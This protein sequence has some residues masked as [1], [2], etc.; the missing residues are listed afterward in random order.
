MKRREFIAG[1]GGA[2]VWPIAVGA[3]QAMPI[4]GGLGAP[5]S[6]PYV[7]NTAAIRQ[8]LKEAG[9]VDG[10]N[11]VLD[12]RWADGDYARL[13]ALA[14]DLVRRQVAAIVT[15]GGTPAILAAKAATSTIPIIFHMGGDPVQLGIVASFNRPGGNITGVTLM[16]TTLEAK[17][18]ELL[19][20]MV[21]AASSI[22]VLVNPT[23]QQS[24]SQEHHI[25]E[26]ARVAG[27]IPLIVR[28][29]TEAE[30]EAAFTRMA[31]ENAGALLIAADVFFASKVPQLAALSVRY[32]IP[33]IAGWRPFASVG[34][35]MSYGTN[36]TD[37][38][39]I[40]G[41]YAGRVLKGEKPAEMPVIE[42][43]RFDFVIN[44]KIA[45]M[46]NIAPPPTLLATADEVIE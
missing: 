24:K 39:R 19:H 43:T 11:I 46:L 5:A 12:F 32:R 28:A 16:A 4:L 2:A 36:I 41:V 42:P 34:G 9:Y 45:K 1:L 38:Y 31:A 8:G 37:A 10:Q 6:A 27:V 30:L 26:A 44:L 20:K 7:H 17:K 40:A 23:N 33:T 13:P 14:A 22:A 25:S 35:L 18:L 21:P 3:Q 29:S 15:V